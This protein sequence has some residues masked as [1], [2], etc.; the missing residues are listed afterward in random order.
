MDV[1]RIFLKGDLRVINSYPSKIGILHLSTYMLC[2]YASDRCINYMIYMICVIYP[3][4]SI[5]RS[6]I[7]YI[8]STYRYIETQT[9]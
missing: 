5:K 4:F 1:N 2:I 9:A 8:K 7:S 6:F 3:I